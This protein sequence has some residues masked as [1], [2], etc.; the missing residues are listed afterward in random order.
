MKIARDY[1]PEEIKSMHLE[2]AESI[3]ELTDE[4]V[5]A[6][7]QVMTEERAKDESRVRYNT[8]EKEKRWACCRCKKRENPDNSPVTWQC[9]GCGGR[10]C[11]RCTLRN[12]KDPRVYYDTTLCSEDCYH[13]VQAESAIVQ[14]RVLDEELE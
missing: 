13:I 4:Q 3:N 9:M 11:H 8:P 6:M 12:A 7:Y 5:V 2:I 10:V 1:N 14:G